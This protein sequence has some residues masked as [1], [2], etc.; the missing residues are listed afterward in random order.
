MR[1]RQTPPPGN[2][3]GLSSPVGSCIERCDGRA[4]PVA[5]R[6]PP[7]QAAESGGVG[8]ARPRHVTGEAP[9]EAFCTALNN[10]NG[11]PLS[12]TFT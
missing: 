7:L 11:A 9:L 8:G 4:K 10:A 5:F 1:P 3:I 6:P 2:A 12:S